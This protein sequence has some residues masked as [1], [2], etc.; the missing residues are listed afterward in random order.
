MSHGFFL[1]LSSPEF[2]KIPST[3]AFSTHDLH[4]LQHQH[5]L[6]LLCDTFFIVIAWIFLALSFHA[7]VARYIECFTLVNAAPS[8]ENG[9]LVWMGL[10]TALSILWIMIRATNPHF[11]KKIEITIGIKLSKR[12]PPIIILGLNAFVSTFFWRK[13]AGYIF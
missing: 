11:D 1:T 4:S 5:F 12:K 10:E 7:T 6:N 8:T 9:L 3:L 13:N 2:L